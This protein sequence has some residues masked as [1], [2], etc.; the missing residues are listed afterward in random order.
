MGANAGIGA[1]ITRVRDGIVEKA[2]EMGKRDAKMED[3]KEVEQLKQKSGMGNEDDD[4][5]LVSK[6]S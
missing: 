1:V 2:K 3:V 5:V 4:L 6:L